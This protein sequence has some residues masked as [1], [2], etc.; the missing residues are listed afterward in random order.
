[1]GVKTAHVQNGPVS[2]WPSS[3]P[4]AEP[5][6][7][8]YGP[9]LCSYLKISIFYTVILITKYGIFFFFFFFFCCCCCCCFS[10]EVINNTNF[11]G[12][13]RERLHA[14]VCEFVDTFLPVDL[15]SSPTP[16]LLPWGLTG[17][18]F[19]VR[20]IDTENSDLLIEAA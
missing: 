8:I 9:L 13:N 1:M 10:F 2:K 3:K 4:A 16:K 15:Y 11:G 14:K 20:Y 17:T 12:M 7:L 18:H 5:K 19:V 6:R